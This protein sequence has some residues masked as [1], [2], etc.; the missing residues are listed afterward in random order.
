MGGLDVQGEAERTEIVVPQEEKAQGD[1]TNVF[2]YLLGGLKKTELDSSQGCPGDQILEQ[3]AQ[4]G[5]R[6]CIPGNT[7]NPAG[8]LDKSLSNLL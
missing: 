2:K 5:C 8:Q 1:V 4:R 7:V 6:V 3:V